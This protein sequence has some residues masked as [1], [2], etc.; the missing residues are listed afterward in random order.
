MFRQARKFTA[1]NPKPQTLNPT[2]SR[3]EETQVMTSEELALELVN[4]VRPGALR[5]HGFDIR[6][7]R[8]W[9]LR[10]MVQGSGFMV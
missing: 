10:F 7:F 5:V 2:C 6:W 4:H 8:V 9:G 3:T 1:L